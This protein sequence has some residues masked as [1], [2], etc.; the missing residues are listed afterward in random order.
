MSILTDKALTDESRFNRN[1]RRPSL[2][3][4]SH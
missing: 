4:T 3:V 1:T 2:H